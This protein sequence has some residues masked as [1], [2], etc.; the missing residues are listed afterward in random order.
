M[1]STPMYHETP[2]KSEPIC[3]QPVGRSGN[4]DSAADRSYRAIAL[5]CVKFCSCSTYYKDSVI[6][7][8]VSCT[9]TSPPAS[10]VRLRNATKRAVTESL[11][12][13]TKTFGRNMAI[14]WLNAHKCFPPRSPIWT[15]CL[16]GTLISLRQI[17]LLTRGDIRSL[18]A[19]QQRQA[20]V[21][22]GHPAISPQAAVP[23]IDHPEH[24]DYL[25]AK[26]ERLERDESG[27]LAKDRKPRS[28]GRVDKSRE[29]PELTNS[30][31]C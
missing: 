23:A 14:R 22:A 11:S 24:V 28:K 18:G 9:V 15:T 1:A 5:F 30:L 27:S 12:A 26:Q 13:R 16:P 20:H 6:R 3:F 21:T 4:F 2:L 19:G 29:L 7:S 8:N 10:L 31:G 17:L 25:D